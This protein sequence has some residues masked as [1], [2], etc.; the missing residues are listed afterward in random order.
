MVGSIVVGDAL[1]RCAL[2]HCVCDLKDAEVNVQSNLIRDLILY[3]FELSHNT[4]K[5]TKNICDVKSKGV[6]DY[7]TVT[8]KL[9]KKFAW[10]TRTLTIKLNRPKNRVLG[11]AP[12]HKDKSGEQHS[13][14]IRQISE[15]YPEPS[16]CVSRY[17]I[18]SNFLFPLVK[19]R[20]Y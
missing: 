16:N 13:E 3:E 4:L 20:F 5:A 10:V 15:K 6:I 14:S 1:T 19:Y 17:Q 7:S 2:L 18:S 12:S 11:R 8:R 9:K